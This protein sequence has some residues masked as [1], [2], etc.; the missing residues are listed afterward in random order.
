MTTEASSTGTRRTTPEAGRSIRVRI[1]C[2]HCDRVVTKHSRRGYTVRCPHCETVNAGPALI[3][4][5]AKP[6]DAGARRRQRSREATA[7]RTQV[8]PASA[9]GAAPVRRKAK[10]APPAPAHPPQQP[11]PARKSA[12]PP[13]ARGFF[14]RVM[15]FDGEEVD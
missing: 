8:D 2:S 3:A 14:S 4:E 7:E 1:V 6:K 12:Q 11:R 9:G 5:Q 13:P 10:A 15:G